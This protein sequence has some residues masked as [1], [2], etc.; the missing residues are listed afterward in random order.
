MSIKRFVLVISTMLFAV[1]AIAQHNH[2][3][4]H[5]MP[6]TGG[7]GS[8]G[9]HGAMNTQGMSPAAKAFTEANAKMQ[10]RKSVV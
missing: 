4:G 2:G 5:Q 6:A 7:H 9:G 1:P 10:D 8:H 3:P